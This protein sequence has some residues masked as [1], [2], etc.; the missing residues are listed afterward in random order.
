MRRWFNGRKREEVNKSSHSDETIMVK[1]IQPKPEPKR[2]RLVVTG[3]EEIPG[4]DGRGF[5]YH[6]RFDPDELVMSDQL[7]VAL[8]GYLSHEIDD[9]MVRH[10]LAKLVAKLRPDLLMTIPE[11]DK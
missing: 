8:L 1:E 10:R 6:T 2:G 4:T 11:T 5:V 3:K 7:A 9:P